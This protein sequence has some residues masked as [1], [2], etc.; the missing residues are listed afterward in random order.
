MKKSGEAEGCRLKAEGSEQ[1][2]RFSS[3]CFV[4]VTHASPSGNTAH[5]EGLGMPRPYESVLT[6]SL[7]PTAFSLSP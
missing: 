5:T 3:D 4:G 1:S 2:A 6:Y 7:Q